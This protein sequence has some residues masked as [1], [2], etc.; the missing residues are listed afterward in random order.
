MNIDSKAK[1]SVVDRRFYT[2]VAVAVA[3]IEKV[4]PRCSF[5][6]DPTE[7]E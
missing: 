4:L 6:Q 7:S 3:L 5:L 2:W 1:R